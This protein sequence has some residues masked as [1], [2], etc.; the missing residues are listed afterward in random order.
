MESAPP[1]PPIDIDD[2]ESDLTPQVSDEEQDVNPG[3]DEGTKRTLRPRPAGPPPKPSGGGAPRP[4][5]KRR[6]KNLESESDEDGSAGIDPEV[7][8]VDSEE[9]SVEEEDL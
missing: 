8:E 4:P 9:E 3:D 1:T 5:K 2:V 6:K 7:P